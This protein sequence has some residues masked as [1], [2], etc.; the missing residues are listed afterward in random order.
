MAKE[1]ESEPLCVTI[2]FLKLR[3]KERERE[4]GTREICSE[5]QIAKL[6]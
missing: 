4:R 2:D 1:G 6:L 5:L 3:G